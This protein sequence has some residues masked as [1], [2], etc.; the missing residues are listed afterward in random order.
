MTGTAAGL[1]SLV[2]TS[3]TQ[4][5]E[6]S[7]R[8][9][10]GGKDDWR[11]KNALPL[12][13]TSGK[14]SPVASDGRVLPGGVQRAEQQDA[15]CCSP[16][17]QGR[18]PLDGA[19]VDTRTPLLLANVLSQNGIDYTFKVCRDY[20]MIAGCVSSGV[21][22]DLDTWRVPAD[23]LEWGKQYHW[24]VT[25]KDR[26]TLGELVTDVDSFT[27]GVRQPVVGS[28]LAT[29]GINGQEFQQV[30][31]NYTTTF[32]DAQVVTA[33][34]PLSV[35]RTYNTLDPRVDGLFGAGWS[36][37]WDM[38]VVSAG[39]ALL[40]TQ[41]DGRVL[42][43]GA[44]GDGTFQPPPGMHATLAE[45]PGGGW[46]LMDKSSTSYLFNASGRVSQVSDN[47][48]RSQNLVYDAQGKLVS[49][50]AT[51]G[52]SLHFGWTGAHV[53]SVSTDPVDGAPLTWTYE[54]DGDR[55]TASCA[56]GAEAACTRYEYGS[57]SIYRSSV[58][59]SQPYGYWRLNE[60]SGATE[61]ADLGWGAGPAD[62]SDATLGQPGALA[63][64]TDPGY[65]FDYRGMALAPNAVGRLAGQMSVETW[66]KTSHPGTVFSAGLA[67]SAD[68]AIYV[69]TD[70]KLRAQFL[71]LAENDDDVWFTPITTTQTVTD[72]QWHH[73]VL[74]ADDGLDRLYLDGQLV[75][76]LQAP[77]SVYWQDDARFAMGPLNWRMPAGG[78][79]NAVFRGQLDE[80]ALYD[81]PL[82]QAEVQA[83]YAA[84]VDAR[85]KLTKVTL[86][87]GRVWA[88]NAYDLVTDRLSTHT[89]QHGGTWKIG[90]PVVD[91][92]AGTSKITVTDPNN[93]TLSSV[94]DIWRGERTKSETDQL[95]KVTRYEYDTGGFHAKMV[96]RNGNT[97][98]RAHDKR[99]NQI[100][101]RT[102]RSAD[103]CQTAYATYHLNDA[104]QFDPRNDRQLTYRDPRSSSAADNTYAT[105]YEYNTYGEP[106]KQTSPATLDFPTGRSNTIA[107]TDGTEAATGGGTTPAGLT[108]TATDARGNTWSY[109]YTA[110]GDLAQQTAPEGLV[111]RL[112]HDPL[113]RITSKTDV[114]QAHPS[115]V[116]ITFTYDAIGRPATQTEPGVK[117][118]ISGVTHT[119]R[120]TY[121]YDLDGNRLSETITDLTG[122]DAERATVYTYDDHGRAETVTGPEGGVVRQTWNT[123]GQLA[124]LTDARGAVIENAYSKRGELTSRTLKAWTGSPVAPQPAADVVLEAFGYDP[125]GRLATQADAMGRKT[126]YTYFDDGLLAKKTADD[127]KLNGSTTPKDVVLEDHTYD[128]AGNRTKLITGGGK[129]TIEYV[130]DA[131][132]RLTTQ[133]LDPGALKRKTAFTYDANGNILTTTRT[134]AGSTR[135]EVTEFTYNKENQ[136]TAQSVE[137]GDQDLI[138]TTA[139]DERGLAVAT[140]DPRGNAEGADSADFTA[141]MRYDSL[142]RLIQVIAPHVQVDK[143]GTAGSGQ[144]SAKFGYDTLGAKTHETDAEGRTVT[145]VFDKAGR[146]TSQIAPSY[147]PPGGTAVTPTT[148]HAY[149]AA[150]QLV[151]T[152]NT[153]G[154]TTTFEFD[155]LGRQVRVTD[156][157]PAGQPAGTW[158]S[159]YDLAGEKLAGID[160]TGARVD[161]TY[162]DL[163]RQIT[164][165][166]IERKP[167]ATAS[168]T[169][170]TYNDAGHL[171]TTVA[172][173]NK[174]TTNTVNAA[175]E[176]TSTTDPMNNKA[177]VTYD[178]AGRPVTATDARGNATTL[179]YDLAGRQIS[180][181]DV[182]DSGAVLRTSSST[183]DLAG[184]EISGTSPE[185]HITR[186]TFDALNRVTSLIEPVSSSESI[187]TGFGYDATGARTRL[188]DGRGNTTWSTYNSLGLIETVTE[189]VTAAHPDAADRTWTVVYDRAGNPTAELQPGG[190]RIDRTFDHLGRPTEETGGGGDAAS[191]ERTFGY[192]LAS[193]ATTIGDLNVNYNDRGLPLTILRGATQQTAY[194]Y[195]NLGNPTERTDA[196]GTATF[197]WDKAS[198][199]DTATD[200]VTGRKLT[201][202]YDE[203]SN[204]TSLTAVQGTT[205]T[206]SQ[207][208]TY[209][210]LDQPLTHTLKSG[211]SSGSQLAKITYAW[212]KDGNLTTKTTAGTAGAGTNTYDYDHA[213]RLTSWTAPGGATTAYEWD[214]AGN[215]TKAG[216][217]T[218]VYDARNRMM[219]GGG[220]TYTYTARGTMASETKDGTTT[221]LTFDAFD[222]LIA[223][224]ESVY[225][226]D[227]LDRVTSRIRGVTKETFA[228][229]G[230]SNDLAAIVDTLGV[231]QARYG[232]D[233]FGALL[234]QKE[235][236]NP[237]LATLTDLHG[238]LVATYS[239]TAL[240]TT[241]AYDPFGAITDQTGAKTNLGY[242]GEY[243]D[244]DT[245]KVNMH[246][247]WYQPGTGTFTSRDTMTLSP[248]P[249]V[250]ANRY[251]YANASPLTHTDPTGHWAVEGNPASGG[252]GWQD[253]APTS[254]GSIPTAATADPDEGWICSG[255]TCFRVRD[256]LY[257]WGNENVGDGRVAQDNPQWYFENF[258]VGNTYL[259]SRAAKPKGYDDAS[260]RLREAYR[261]AYDMGFGIEELASFWKNIVSAEKGMMAGGAAAVPDAPGL[262]NKQ[263]CERAKGKKACAALQKTADDLV[264][265]R[266]YIN[267]CLVDHPSNVGY[268]SALASSL[269][270][271]QP[272]HDLMVAMKRSKRGDNWVS[273]VAKG[274]TDFVFEDAMACQQGNYSSCI[275]MAVS[276]VP[277][278]GVASK[279]ATKVLGK[280]A[281]AS[282]NLKGT[283][284]LGKVFCRRSS[285]VVGTLVL[286][287]DG[288][289]KPIEEVV[290]GDMV[291]ATDPL[292]GET[293]AKEVVDLIVGTGTKD[294]VK[295]TM[296][297]GSAGG[298]HDPS[299]TATA[300]H[301]FWVP[302]SKQW[303]N[304]ADLA[305]GMWLRTSAG[306]YIQVG[307]VKQQTSVQRVHNMTVGDLHTYY[308]LAGEAPVLVHNSTCPVLRSAIHDDPLLVRAAQKAGKDQKVQRD[309]DAMQARLANG[310]MNPGIGSGFLSGTD[311]AYARSKNG[312]R[313]YFRN[314]E[315]GIQI[316]GKSDK[317]NQ[318]AVIARLGKLYG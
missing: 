204:L 286:M 23:K 117:N 131:A 282:P 225:S 209:D 106:T 157:A 308:V 175:G 166:E 74:T 14:E 6:G 19:L 128:A 95:G 278:G 124:S 54:Y 301:P 298:E 237:A 205:T 140:I 118:E 273:M 150:G 196:A 200:P 151:S 29:R 188:T 44:N 303:V 81:R 62:A 194:T 25:A 123:L 147:T 199:L 172:P 153:R 292:T 145:A 46:R 284:K 121:A 7:Q 30:T 223:D 26:G 206:D 217:K 251:T 13:R 77:R 261:I 47:R 70:G 264:A 103:D 120:V 313:L 296:T 174:T 191:A 262:L 257:S 162:D 41:S 255:W 250:Q 226:Y 102:C 105:T 210:D 11:P 18:F 154:Y 190:V 129:T 24:Q 104:D 75:G 176:V 218:Y 82:T 34:P 89:D 267:I 318:K 100:S 314:T 271:N 122:G 101:S 136:V 158:V 249:S 181:K 202:G 207:A 299:L 28:Q 276:F 170:L 160:P 146:L 31:G 10:G 49:V 144:P 27:T 40:V 220:S 240:A 53:T 295:I 216:D 91:T 67:G 33:G 148:Q 263:A 244:P 57:G 185:G 304:A 258:V 177:T 58:L 2:G 52:R 134:G 107:Y 266:K 235:G 66:F 222:R 228:Y 236:A 60:T 231:V 48:G 224:G 288:S 312:A 171:L 50:T 238:D 186:Q 51:G 16:V 132:G 233:A 93:G 272:Q 22:E 164:V 211:T 180:A 8:S 247:R 115:G 178:L 214:A 38:K 305:P 56:P 268:C 275:M 79:G 159:E 59:D 119:K 116:K 260:L 137:N 88:E 197:T 36:T 300:E 280:L 156:P 229:S 289:H 109:G 221:Q 63:G 21:L 42:R 163:G 297:P 83:H 61:A 161:T 35:V 86:P 310:N 165:T 138:T 130:Y 84:R 4:A 307:A 111:T 219:S 316:V 112:E 65:G 113:G 125:G 241:T 149:D 78:T 108:K 192:D 215:R 182:N 252:S 168:T 315:F 287:A 32:T 184:N 142:G 64:T 9:R 143:A 311:V 45:Q 208:F 1:P 110:S 96:D 55:L 195:D 309:L 127:V 253:W 285:F 198:R 212:D 3:V 92:T 265:T 135:S 99:G 254:G 293:A 317:K 5:S 227:A 68:S 230:L 43:F 97:S 242:Q 12:E 72:G 243:T 20:S 234:G 203:V 232:R 256:P 73:A 15:A 259:G 302:T 133:M 98:E 201:Y 141:A 213:G 90:K 94:H 152:T 69:G 283:T 290:V 193:R 294:L 279:A 277:G 87:S 80:A 183:Y 189:P 274:V 246:A 71:S 37:R 167:V 291:L 139:Y 270:I 155:Q 281:K 239:S 248:N 39:G 169:T 187:T 306:T 76:A 269:N 114:S 126:T 179:E 173:G 85:N 17:L 245:G